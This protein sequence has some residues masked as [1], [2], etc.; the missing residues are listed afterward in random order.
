M[1][2]WAEVMGDYLGKRDSA[3]SKNQT[4]FCDALGFREKGSSS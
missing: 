2:F 1:R 4:S 3:I